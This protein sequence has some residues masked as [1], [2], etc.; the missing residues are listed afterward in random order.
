MDGAIH[1]ARIRALGELAKT[2]NAEVGEEEISRVATRYSTAYAVGYVYGRTH[3]DQLF[4]P[5]EVPG[6]NEEDP[7]VIGF[8]EG[9]CDAQ[10]ENTREE[11][12][13]EDAERNAEMFTA[14]KFDYLD[15]LR[16]YTSEP[17]ERVEPSARKR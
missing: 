15:I 5:P 6:R 7:D 17:G 16:W 11:F 4:D 9:W 14:G 12:S 8:I 10:Y 13:Q 1:G 2:G 3:I